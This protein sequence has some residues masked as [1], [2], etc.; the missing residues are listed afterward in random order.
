MAEIYG[1]KTHPGE[2]R[3]FRS[4][5]RE[6]T[7]TTFETTV[8]RVLG[9]LERHEF[10][11]ETADRMLKQ[12]VASVADLIR[13]NGYG[14]LE[15]GGDGGCLAA[16]VIVLR[17]R[18]PMEMIW[19]GMLARTRSW[20]GKADAFER[21]GCIA[22]FKGSPDECVVSAGEMGKGNGR[23]LSRMAELADKLAAECRLPVIYYGCNVL[24]PLYNLLWKEGLR[25]GV[26]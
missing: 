5:F 11:K 19:H 16:T 24:A 25:E 12:N 8:G 14:A 18:T 26:D 23:Q 15:L 4:T 2:A 3:A 6:D 1:E 17:E 7:R 10:G 13:R 20:T 21:V 9:Q 22:F